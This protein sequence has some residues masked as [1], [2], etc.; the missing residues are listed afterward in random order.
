MKME[1]Y[2]NR[3]QLGL[4]PLIMVIV[5]LG[6]QFPIYLLQHHFQIT[7]IL[8]LL[9]TVLKVFVSLFGIY[10]I[11]LTVEKQIAKPKKEKINKNKK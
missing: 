11:G 9:F 10:L 6:I 2:I 3:I 5:A 4:L 8:Y 1:K 7:G